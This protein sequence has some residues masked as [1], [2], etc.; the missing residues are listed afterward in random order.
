MQRLLILGSLLLSLTCLSA[1]QAFALDAAGALQV[2][3]L[4]NGGPVSVRDVSKSLY[5]TG[6][7]DT[8][9]LD[10]LAEVMLQ[11]YQ[12]G[13][14]TN[15]DAMAWGTKALGQ[16]GLNRYRSTLQEIADSDAHRKLRKY[17]SKALKQL[18]NGSDAQ[19]VKGSVSLKQAGAKAKVANAAP[20]AGKPSAAPAATGKQPLS[21]VKEGMGMSEVYALVGQPTATHN[22]QTGKAWIPFNFKGGDTVRMAALY[23]GQGRVVFANESHY[24]A[25]WRVIGVELNANESGYP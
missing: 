11:T 22:Y 1:G 4:V 20:A 21:V 7:R 13:S 5:H 3:R 24:S 25:G 9:V 19:Y 16:S 17:A 18:N 10:V 8:E 14:N 15:I 2:D 23:K 6:S 12:D